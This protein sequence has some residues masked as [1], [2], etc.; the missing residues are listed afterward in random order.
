MFMFA[1]LAACGSKQAEPEAP[2][3]EEPVAEGTAA[4]PVAE[5]ATAEGTDDVPAEEAAADA[6][7]E[8]AAADAPAEEAAADAPAEEAAATTAEAGDCAPAATIYLQVNAPLRAVDDVAMQWRLAVHDSGYW[9]NTSPNGEQTGCVTAADLA[10]LTTSLAAA[11]ISAPELE[12]G[13]ARCM[14]MPMTQYT[15]TVGDQT[16]SWKGPCGMNNPSASLNEL[17]GLVESVSYK[18][19]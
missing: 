2:A 4:A 19:Q 11:D 7:A 6:P 12:P 17:I 5:E 13:M 10:T 9:S 16:A 14:A 1:I 18:K 8:E 3:A 15:I